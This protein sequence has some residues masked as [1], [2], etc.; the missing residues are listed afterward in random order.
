MRLES[1]FSA[2]IKLTIAAFCLVNLPA[3]VRAQNSHDCGEGVTLNLSTSASSQGALL[4]LDV[5]SAGSPPEVEAEWAGHAIPFWQ[6][7]AHEK[8]RHAL[9]GVDLEQPAGE[10]PLDLT[11]QLIGGQKVSCR[12]VVSVGVGHFA[13][14][15]LHVAREFV[16]L[17]PE[18]T[19]R[20][21]KERQRLRE[22]FA[23][24]TPDRLW[25]G[26]FRLPLD[27]AHSAANF[28][29][30]R[31]LNGQPGSPH[32]GADFPAPAGTSV[33]A[34]QRGR[35]V[36]AEALFFSGNTVLLDHGLGLYTFYGHL[37]SIG[38]HEGDVVDSGA[39]LGRVGATGRVTGPH[40]HWGLIVNQARVNPLEI[41]SLRLKD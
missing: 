36:L 22:F 25:K 30:R 1:A 38:V 39:I 2:A 19:E 34:A 24:A 9:L 26:R 28:G 40:L 31:I 37:E 10:F 16:E 27:G 17:S 6:D 7:T 18:D 14:E 32:G 12:V 13:I 15:K 41:V 33:H 35:V 5:S 29:R 11:A 4:R 8:I 21:A 20:A 23:R 3:T